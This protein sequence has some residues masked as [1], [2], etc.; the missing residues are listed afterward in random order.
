[1]SISKEAGLRNYPA[2]QIE[3]Q[4]ETEGVKLNETKVNVI[5]LIRTELKNVVFN[6]Q[7]DKDLFKIWLN[8]MDF[9]LEHG[10]TVKLMPSPSDFVGKWD[11]TH[12]NGEQCNCECT[13]P[14]SIVISSTEYKVAI[15]GSIVTLSYNDAS[16]SRY[17]V[18]FLSGDC[19]AFFGLEF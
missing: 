12:W 11:A 17:Q 3:P 6:G 8:Y 7:K 19:K 10:Q 4:R 1:M 9:E 13:K 15:K 18:G 14:D 16:L 5:G 2:A